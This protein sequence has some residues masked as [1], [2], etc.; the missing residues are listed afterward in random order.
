[1]EMFTLSNGVQMPAE[2]FGVFQVNDLAV[3]KQAVLDA[4]DAGYR[5]IDT[6]SLYNNEEAVGDAV[7]E[8]IAAG[9]VTREELF[10]TTKL[11]TNDASYEGAKRSFETSMKYLGLDYL[12]MFMIHMPYGDIYG[13]WKAMEEM[14][15]EGKI[16][17]LAVSNFYAGKLTEFAEI[18]DVKPHVDQLELHPFYTRYDVIEVMK[19]YGTV[20][21]AWGPLAE[22]NHGIFTHPVL[23][24]IGAK[25]GKTPAQVALRWNVQRGVSILPKSVH[26]DRIE[27]NIDIWDFAL[28]DEDMKKV[29]TLDLG[30]SEIVDHNNPMSVKFF[31][32]V[33]PEAM[34]GFTIK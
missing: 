17:A 13:A 11:W 27:Q 1:M 5:L 15:S 20:P 21:Q 8:A 22:G 30:H 14:Y 9:K 31:V 12:D 3:C 34:K 2:G 10:I 24:E 23:A 28:T 6:A 16:R 7:A 29:D 26:R 4:I 33:T 32:N 18:V 19:E 25:Y